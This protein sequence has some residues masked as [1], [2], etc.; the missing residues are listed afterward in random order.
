[1]E[2]YSLHGT[3]LKISK[4]A[5]GTWRM[6]KK[7][8]EDAEKLI[9]GALDL[10]INFFDE[11]DVYG[12]GKSE[13]MFGNV[14]K[15]H[16][17]IRDQMILQTKVGIV[18]G[19]PGRYDSSKE[20][21]LSAVD[22][23]LKRLRTDHLDVLL[24][25]RPDALM[26]PAETAEAIA[27]L[28]QSGKVRYFG[29]SNHT[30]G[31]IELLKKYCGIPLLINQLEFSIVHSLMVDQGIFA[32][33][34]EEWSVDHDGAILN[35]CMQNDIL[36]QAWSTVQASLRGGTFIDSPNYPKL[37]KCMD[38]LCEKYQVGKNAIALS[39]VLKHPA[40][41]QPIV[42]TTTIEHLKASADALQVHLTN[43]E[44][45]DLYL[46]EGKPLP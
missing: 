30:P 16:P 17:G 26:D 1:M 9:L 36:I 25:H 32:N 2:Y 13:E 39:W 3:D 31:Q 29:V 6:A 44:W 11:A 12:R 46:A 35:Y 33:M 28:H 34:S 43:Q 24:L 23:S 8:D 27:L 38:S 19:E 20:H 4:L 5:L 7:T 41:M 21:L 18:K 40:H 42:G 22:A 45:Y 10:G 37:N 14:L 15:L